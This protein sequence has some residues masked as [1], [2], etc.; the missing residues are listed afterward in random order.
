MQAASE[1][2]VDD[3]RPLASPATLCRLKNRVN[4]ASCVKLSELL[5]EPFIRS[6]DAPGNRVFNLT[7]SP[8][9]PGEG[10]GEGSSVEKPGFLKIFQ[11]ALSPALVS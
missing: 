11:T 1:R 7:P 10:W 2:E 3:A 5:V 6:F 9:T 4:H 8:G